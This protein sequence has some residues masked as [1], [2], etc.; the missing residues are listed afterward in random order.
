MMDYYFEKHF[1]I[2]TKDVDQNNHCRPSA[3]L[4]FLQEAAT[5]ASVALGVSRGDMLARYNVFWMLARIWFRVERPLHCNEVLTVRTWHRGGRGV[6]MYRDFDL[7]VEGNLVG[8][9]VSN[10]VLADQVNRKMLRMSH[11][12]L[13]GFMKTGGSLCKTMTLNKLKRPEKMELAEQRLMHDS[14]TD[15]NGHVNNARYADFALDVL[16]PQAME[17]H[18]FVSDMQ[19]GYLAECRPGE[20]LT[21]HRSRDGGQYFVRGVGQDEVVRFDAAVTLTSLIN[22]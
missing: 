7:Y 6:S 15:I 3:L 9:A 10:W 17:G 16:Y 12:E 22:T 18:S 1:M 14:E 2:G 13:D 5:A 8:E 21:I 19:L 20:V 11:V 4:S